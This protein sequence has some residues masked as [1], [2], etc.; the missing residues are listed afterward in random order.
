MSRVLKRPM[1]KKGGSVNEGI[2]HGLVDRRGYATAGTVQ[3]AKDLSTGYADLMAEL[4]PPPE[5]RSLSE[6]LIGGGLNLVS[7]A[8]A[9]QGLMANIARSY[10]GPSEKFFERQRDVRDYDR[11]LKMAGAKYGIQQAM[12]E[13]TKETKYSNTMR[14]VEEAI[15]LGKYPDTLEGRQQAWDALSRSTSDWVNK[16]YDQKFQEA[17]D[18]LIKQGYSGEELDQ[19]ADYDARVKPALVA[20]E[21]I[22]YTDL[23]GILP[24]RKGQPNFSKMIVGKIYYD[25][26]DGQAKI[27]KGQDEATGEYLLDPIEI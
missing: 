5:D 10:K 12:E 19:R 24:R 17:K 7:G 20:Q 14:M 11:Q 9:G 8:G 26:K 2:M 18:D 23:G 6:M 25:L 4:V 1:F 21:G 22:S 13:S 3:R 27:Y 15:K 16:S